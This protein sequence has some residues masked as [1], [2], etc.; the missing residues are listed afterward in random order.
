M[1]LSGA[2]QSLGGACPF[3]GF[4]L[5]GRQVQTDGETEFTKGDCRGL[6]NGTEVV[7]SGVQGSD[8]RVRAESVTTTKAK[9]GDEEDDGGRGGRGND[10]D[11]DKDTEKDGK[12]G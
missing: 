7:A 3:V 6:R 4:T 8:G 2:I 9:K 10:K 1:T 12:K 5:E 11:K